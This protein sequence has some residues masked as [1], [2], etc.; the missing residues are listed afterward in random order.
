MNRIINKTVLDGMQE[1]ADKS[2]DCVITSP[3]YWQL[4]DYGFTE[5]WGL[6]KTYNEYLEH[7]WRLMNEIYRVLKDSGTV[8]I[9]L[10]DSYMNNSSYCK[11]GRQGFNKDKIGV[12]NKFLEADKEAGQYEVL[13]KIHNSL[14]MLDM[15]PSTRLVLDNLFLDVVNIK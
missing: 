13:E 3:P 4:R 7:L 12:L 9:N 1:I 14:A 6:E 10:G 2:I 11:E 5:Q 8:W 15:N